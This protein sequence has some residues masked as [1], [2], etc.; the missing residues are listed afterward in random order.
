[1]SPEKELE[2]FSYNPKLGYNPKQLKDKILESKDKDDTE[3]FILINHSDFLE[4][5]LVPFDEITDL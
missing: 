5:Q 1:M 2:A 3:A 4:N